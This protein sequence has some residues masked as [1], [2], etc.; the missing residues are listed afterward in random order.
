M[1]DNDKERKSFDNQ[2]N[3][4]SIGYYGHFAQYFDP[5]YKVYWGVYHDDGWGGS[6]CATTQEELDE[7]C[8][9]KSYQSW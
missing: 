2:Q 5:E 1:I 7:M 8:K 6:W 4:M 3:W 9:E